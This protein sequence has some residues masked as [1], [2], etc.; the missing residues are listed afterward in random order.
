MDGFLKTVSGNKTTNI[1][2]AFVQAADKAK[3]VARDIGNVVVPSNIR[4]YTS[5]LA[6]DRRTITEKNLSQADKDAIL[7]A[8][9]KSAKATKNPNQGVIGYGDYGPNGFSN[10]AE[11]NENMLSTVYDSYTD[12]AYRMETTLGMASWRRLPDGSYVIEDRY[13]FNAT[14]PQVKNTIAKQGGVTRTLL[15]AYKNRGVS[16]VLNAAGNIYGDTETERGN[17]VRIRLKPRR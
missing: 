10:F 7:F 9:Q 14:R 5:H 6:G 16:G 12:P 15:D 3:S 11:P 8:I 13:N 17:A 2:N 1:R 4:I